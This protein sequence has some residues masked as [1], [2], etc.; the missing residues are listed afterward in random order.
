[1]FVPLIFLAKSPT[2]HFFYILLFCLKMYVRIE[3][4]E[5]DC[6]GWG[7]G[8]E[9]EQRRRTNKTKQKTNKNHHHEW[10][11]ERWEG[12]GRWPPRLVD[13]DSIAQY[14]Q[15]RPGSE[16]T[17]SVIAAAS[18]SNEGGCPSPRCAANIKDSPAVRRPSV[19]RPET[20]EGHHRTW[21]RL[22]RSPPRQRDA[23]GTG[24][25]SC[26]QNKKVTVA[27]AVGDRHRAVG[28]LYRYSA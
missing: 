26:H 16:L 24:R 5:E 3:Y 28:S 17:A 25:G 4:K 27:S 7:G 20:R 13:Y 8:G 9:A 14:L 18:E 15:T 22:A 2:L 11:K 10:K 1:M 21:H 12:R 19:R 6:G 23:P